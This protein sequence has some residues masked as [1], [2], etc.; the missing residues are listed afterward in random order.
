MELRGREVADVLQ[1]EVIL[2]HLPQGGE[3]RT[4][5]PRTRQDDTFPMSPV[6][7]MW[8][9]VGA[10]PGWTLPCTVPGALGEGLAS[11]HCGS[12]WTSKRG[13]RQHLVFV[14]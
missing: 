5:I 12:G 11:F 1:V 6:L 7:E 2:A 4:V 9:G 13:D 14:K 8:G 10:G 3:S